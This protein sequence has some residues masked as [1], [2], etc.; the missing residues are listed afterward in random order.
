[1][2]VAISRAIE[3]LIVVINGNEQQ[4]DTII[5]ELVKYIDDS[6][7]KNYETFNKLLHEYAKQFDEKR[8]TVG[9]YTEKSYRIK[10]WLH[11]AELP[12]FSNCKQIKKQLF[13]D[14]DLFLFSRPVF[15]SSDIISRIELDPLP[16]RDYTQIE[17]FSIGAYHEYS[18]QL[19]F[20][21]IEEKET[22]LEK[23]K[24]KPENKS[25]TEFWLVI[26][27]DEIEQIYIHNIDLLTNVE[28]GYRHIFAVKGVDF[29]TLK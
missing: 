29:H 4:K 11:G 2:N 16:N 23:Y 25:L 27:F 13:H 14:L 26:C 1:M 7:V 3:Q 28:T 18:K 12:N 24:E 20:K 6:L 15:F 21:R 17:V 19:L 22:K 5:N 8:K 9:N 10:I